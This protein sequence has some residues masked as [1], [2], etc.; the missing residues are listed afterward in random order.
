MAILSPSIRSVCAA[1]GEVSK[2]LIDVVEGIPWDHVG[3]AIA[4]HLS[5][6]LPLVINSSSIISAYFFFFQTSSTALRIGFISI[7][8]GRSVTT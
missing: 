1:P 4:D 8:S 2:R 5:N 3:I 6:L 7:H